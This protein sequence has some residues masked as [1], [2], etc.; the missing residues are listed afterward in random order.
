MKHF[1][2]VM[3]IDMTARLHVT[4]RLI[5]HNAKFIFTIND[6]IHT[7]NEF[8]VRLD[9]MEP[10]ELS[11]AVQSGAVEIADISVNG[12]QIL[13]I[14]LNLATPATSWIT[15]K[16]NFNIDRPFYHWHHDITGQGFIA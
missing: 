11:C 4:V 14:Y 12:N 3:A 15:D 16:W 7:D 5:P 6:I 2:D 8:S 10:I 13:P 9:L 1:S